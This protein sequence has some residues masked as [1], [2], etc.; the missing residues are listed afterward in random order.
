MSKRWLFTKP[1]W[2]AKSVPDSPPTAAPIAKAQ[3]L[4]R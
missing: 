3:I 4:K 2:A 1:T